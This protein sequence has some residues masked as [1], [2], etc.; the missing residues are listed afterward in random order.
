MPWQEFITFPHSAS[1]TKLKNSN[2]WEIETFPLFYVFWI[3]I[4]YFFHRIFSLLAWNLSFFGLDALVFRKY[5]SVLTGFYTFFAKNTM[6]PSS[7]ILQKANKWFCLLNPPHWFYLKTE[8]LMYGPH[9][10]QEQLL[11]RKDCNSETTVLRICEK[12]RWNFKISKL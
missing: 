10:L 4:F 11:C 1:A 7:A 9:C 5:F 12:H 2:L 8:L 3:T 6:F